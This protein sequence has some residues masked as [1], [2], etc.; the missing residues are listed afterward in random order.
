M[1][2]ISHDCVGHSLSH[3]HH[4]GRFFPTTYLGPYRV[5]FILEKL[6]FQTP[7][8]CKDKNLIWE[9]ETNHETPLI[10][11]ETILKLEYEIAIA[12]LEG[13]TTLS[14]YDGGDMLPSSHLDPYGFNIVMGEI[15]SL[16]GLQGA[17]FQS[18]MK[19]KERVLVLKDGN[20]HGRS[21]KMRRRRRQQAIKWIW[22]V[23]KE[24]GGYL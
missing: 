19:C 12:S 8:K 16:K 21:T 1:D 5:S 22:L 4:D 17:T 13:L 6:A 9:D 3:A 24:L 18:S 11:H 23:R 14:N 7:M 20:P 2:K 10:I 15:S